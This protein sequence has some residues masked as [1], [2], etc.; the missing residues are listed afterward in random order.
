[1]I[2]RD[3]IYGRH[4]AG[5]GAVDCTGA[6]LRFGDIVRRADG[7]LVQVWGASVSPE[8]RAKWL[9]GRVV[10]DE[11]SDVSAGLS[12]ACIIVGLYKGVPHRQA[13]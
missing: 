9:R 7:I 5:I 13:S 12:R 11:T 6:E 4:L 1:M 8:P 3:R 10:G 2:P